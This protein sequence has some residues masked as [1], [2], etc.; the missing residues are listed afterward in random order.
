MYLFK[1]KYEELKL[2]RVNVFGVF[3]FGTFWELNWAN[4]LT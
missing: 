1:V 3:Y 4:K 2:V